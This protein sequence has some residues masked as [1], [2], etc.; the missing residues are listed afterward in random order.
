[1]ESLYQEVRGNYVFFC[2]LKMISR[3]RA[4]GDMKRTVTPAVQKLYLHR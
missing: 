4:C 3:S 2:T 1:M